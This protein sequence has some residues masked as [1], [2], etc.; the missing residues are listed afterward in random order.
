[1][2]MFIDDFIRRNCGGLNEK[3]KSELK[4]DYLNLNRARLETSI[5]I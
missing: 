1:M 2:E 3:K 5:R 4:A